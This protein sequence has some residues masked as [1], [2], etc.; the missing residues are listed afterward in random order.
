MTRR[1]LGGWLALCL[2]WA[3]V[4]PC[5]AADEVDAAF[6]AGNQ[7]AAKRH[8]KRAVRH[9]ERARKLSPGRS[10]NLSYNLGTAYAHLGQLGYATVH[11]HHA[12]EQ[13]SDSQL[14]EG[15]R[16]N[17]GLVRRQAETQAAAS[18]RVL[19]DPPHWSSVV[20]A[21]L[22]NSAVGWCSVALW[23]I[24][25][26]LVIRRLRQ[27]ATKSWVLP[28]W[29]VSGALL[30]ASLYLY[31]AGE[32]QAGKYIVVGDRVALREGPG[33]HRSMLFEVQPSSE[34]RV[35]SRSSGWAQVRL[36]GARQGWMLSRA[37][38]PLSPGSAAIPVGLQ[39]RSHSGENSGPEQASR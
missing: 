28:F 19:S 1:V 21:F 22:G 29:C 16:Q 25:A 2:G 26:L 8:W 24:S 5:H 23:W 38:A 3:L 4:I 14:L 18:N 11:L 35:L 36:P 37:L 33:E 7:A 20:V 30:S 27:G 39:Q 9:Y 15:A 17:L 32:V 6:A 10:A 34:L 12:L 13:G 31:C